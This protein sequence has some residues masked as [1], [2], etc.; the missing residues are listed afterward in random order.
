M[1]V[2]CSVICSVSGAVPLPDVFS[3]E[4]GSLVVSVDLKAVARDVG[5]QWMDLAN[6]LDMET[7]NIPS[8]RPG[9]LQCRRML[10]NWA[11]KCGDNAMICVLC[12]ALYESGLQHVADQHYGHI[13]DTVLRKQT[14]SKHPIHQATSSVQTGNSA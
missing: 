14:P 5:D 13:V 8:K 10:D 2:C 11:K 12:D 1:A 7:D 9:T 4:C 3:S 6:E